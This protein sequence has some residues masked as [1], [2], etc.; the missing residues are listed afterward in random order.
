[1]E[2]LEGKHNPAQELRIGIFSPSLVTPVVRFV[3][4]MAGTTSP[5]IIRN[6]LRSLE[7]ATRG[8]NGKV[9]ELVRRASLVPYSIFGAP[10]S[11]W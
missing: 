2:I 6:T 5:L 3:L 11:V 7:N 8:S 4:G 9:R 1:M 10:S